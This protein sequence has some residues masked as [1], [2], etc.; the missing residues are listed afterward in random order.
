MTQSTKV[1]YISYDGM[2]DP[3]G[4]SQVIPYIEGLTRQGLEFHLLS[5]EKP[6]RFATEF[7][8][9][10]AK[11]LQANIHWH[12]IPYTSRPPVLSTL[13]DIRRLKK[14]ATLLHS[15]HHFQ[16]THCR[17]YIAAFVG[18]ML[19]KKE[20]VPFIF[21]MRGFWADERID[22]KL[23]NTKNPIF[24][25]IYK[26]F[27][28]KEKE[29]LH[30]SDH[31]VT[32]TEN[33]KSEIIQ[34][35]GLKHIP[36]ISV[37]PCCVDHELFSRDKV[38]ET[39]KK[40]WANKL[41]IKSDDLIISYS[42]SVGTWYMLEEMLDFFNVLSEKYSNAKFLFI[43]L[44]EPEKIMSACHSKNIDPNRIII[45]KAKRNE[46]P[47]LLSLSTLSL[48]FIKPAYSKKASSPTKMGELMSMG[49]PFITNSGVG[50]IDL[51]VNEYKVGIAIKEQTEA[52]YSE[53][54]ES[55]PALLK[56]DIEVSK[57]VAKTK[58]SLEFGVASY[59]NIYN[60][61]KQNSQL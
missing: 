25:L 23:W 12:P 40:V 48:F 42:G 33:G 6:E 43:T 19:K 4:Q 47:V 27:K 15:E 20:K 38:T 58:Y 51:L 21:D 39:E 24:Y 41:K 7:D 60:Q 34:N 49:I 11:L 32:L 9:I 16:A 31:V 56:Q 2:T 28:K 8:Q 22:G 54:I 50:D 55:I 57:E 46:M 1:L 45:C 37:I 29:F 26:Y 30:H 14:E 13:K 18:L 3:L 44:D 5:C 10:S 53:A 17:S 59:F 61:L 36:A 52:A 35:F